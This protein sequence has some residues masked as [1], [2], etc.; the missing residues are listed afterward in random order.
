MP[1]L[2]T[3]REAAILGFLAPIR[4]SP[5]LNFSEA[6]KEIKI[7]VWASIGGQNL[8]GLLLVR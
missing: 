1:S 4:V 6:M 5:D 7:N 2:G 8:I 3:V